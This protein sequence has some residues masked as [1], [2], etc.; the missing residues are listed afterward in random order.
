M[1]KKTKDMIHF[2]GRNNSKLGMI[3]TG[4]GIIDMMGFIVVCVV[5]G[6]SHGNGGMLIGIAGLFLFGLSVAGF[7]ISYKSLKEKDIFYRFPIIGTTLN[8]IMMVVLMI[9]YV[10]GLC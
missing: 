10:L 2:S 6:M 8:G 3:S 5:S 1:L 4:I 7:F 9:L